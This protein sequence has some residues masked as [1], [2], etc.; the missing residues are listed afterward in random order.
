MSIDKLLF[1]TLSSREQ[2]DDA[3][4][5]KLKTMAEDKIETTNKRKPVKRLIV[6]AAVLAVLA[7][8]TALAAWIIRT[9]AEVAQN[10]GYTKLAEAFDSADAIIVNQ[11]IE[12]SE[13]R[14]TLLGIVSGKMLE[15]LNSEIEPGNSYIVTAVQKKDGSSMPE[16]NSTEYSSIY[17]CAYIMGVMPW[18]YDINLSGCSM[19]SD[20]IHYLLISCNTLEP[21][22]DRVIYL[23]VSN[24]V[25]FS[26]DAYNYDIETGEITPN[27][28]YER[29]NVLFELPLDK[30]KANPEL[31]AAILSGDIERIEPPVPETAP[32]GDVA[33]SNTSEVDIS[34]PKGVRDYT[35]DELRAYIHFC[36]TVPLE[37]C[38]LVED[39]VKVLELDKNGVYKYM[40]E[41]ETS[42]IECGVYPSEFDGTNI[43]R[44][45]SSGGGLDE[46]F[47]IHI[48]TKDEEGVV[49]GMLYKAPV[50]QPDE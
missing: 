35:E 3:L 32:D 18:Q 1:L 4:N 38:E 5:M 23:T 45:G 43:V 9:P 21:F 50:W 2:P 10:F 39:S 15:D 34:S 48:F 49:R 14:V 20:G 12:S 7:S 41:C 47:F 19:I 46:A 30:S 24:E 44:N 8:V 42:R 25:F 37:D 11:S 33:N 27:N 22:A 40:Y 17:A 16:F 36:F 29:L 13:Y 6:I 26:H 31:A 28:D